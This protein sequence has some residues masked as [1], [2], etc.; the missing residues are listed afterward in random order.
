ML[1]RLST[2]TCYLNAHMQCNIQ[3]TN[4]WLFCRWSCSFNR[5]VSD[6]HTCARFIH[7]PAVFII[8][9]HSELHSIKLIPSAHSFYTKPRS[10]SSPLVQSHPEAYNFTNP[11]EDAYASNNF[12]VFY[13]LTAAYRHAHLTVPSI[14]ILS[15]VIYHRCVE[16][17]PMCSI[18]IILVLPILLHMNWCFLSSRFFPISL[19]LIHLLNG[20]LLNFKCEFVV[21]SQFHW[22]TTPLHPSPI[23]P[24][25]GSRSRWQWCVCFIF[26]V[27]HETL[28]QHHCHPRSIHP[29]FSFPFCAV[30]LDPSFVFLL[31][32]L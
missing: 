19:P 4:R 1:S 21:V 23:L 9:G 24:S 15:G 2:N 28:L 17:L 18:A 5:G 29:P 10:P 13:S 14:S 16:L 8:S 32:P 30:C 11:V 26:D 27:F 22:L 3:W 20:W 12:P 7:F 6:S 25:S 31:P